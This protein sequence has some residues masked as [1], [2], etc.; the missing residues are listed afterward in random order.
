MSI[1]AEYQ[2]TEIFNKVMSLGKAVCMPKERF[3]KW[4]AALRSGEYSQCSGTLKSEG[5]NT[6]SFCCLGVEQQ[7]NQGDVERTLYGAP[8]ELLLLNI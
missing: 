7:V 5:E 3:E 4:V 2:E 1:S 6:C 8:E